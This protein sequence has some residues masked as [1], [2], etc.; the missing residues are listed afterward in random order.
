MKNTQQTKTCEICGAEYKVKAYRAPLSRYCSKECWSHRNPP[1][2][3]PCAWCGKPFISRFKTAMFCS[4]QC[5]GRPRVGE[6]AGAWKGGHSL[7]R[8]RSAAKGDLAKWRIAVFERDGFKCRL[9]GNGGKFHAHHVESIAEHPERII[10]VTNGITVCIPCH[11]SIHGRKL[12]TPA[13]YP[14]HCLRCGKKTSGRSIHCRPC[15]ITISWASGH[16]RSLHPLSQK[17]PASS[18]I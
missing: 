1:V 8:K 7:N 3:K 15:S 13:Q 18:V 9:C 10:D 2:E 4:R 6:K 5:A 17:R 16:L 11:E 12:A 14:K